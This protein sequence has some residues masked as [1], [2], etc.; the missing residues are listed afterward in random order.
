MYL[1]DKNHATLTIEDI[2]Y[3]GFYLRCIILL[4]VKGTLNSDQIVH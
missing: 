1:I 4:F 3:V 2:I